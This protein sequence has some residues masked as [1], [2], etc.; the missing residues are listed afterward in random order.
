[1]RTNAE[2]AHIEQLAEKQAANEAE[3]NT[4]AE[5]WAAPCEDI[6]N[7]WSEIGLR[8]NLVPTLTEDVSVPRVASPV[9]YFSAY[10]SAQA[11]P[12]T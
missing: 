11:S 6:Q 7:I 9:A 1:M 8:P 4:L 5:K 3:L 2:G 10:V 12:R